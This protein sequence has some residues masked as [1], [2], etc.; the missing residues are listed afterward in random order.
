[1]PTAL[2]RPADSADGIRDS[3]QQD[4]TSG[5]AADTQP[6]RIPP[7]APRA[8]LPSLTGMRWAAALLV[9]LSHIKNFGY[10]GGTAGKLVDW[11]FGRGSIGVSFF[12]ILS[13]FVLAWSVR[14]GERAVTFWRNR[15]ARVY[16]LHLVTAGIA[17][18]LAFTLIPAL[19]PSGVPEAL[20]NVF[21]VSSWNFEWWQ[22]LNPV[23]WTLTC[24]A[25]FYALFPVLYAALRRLGTRAHNPGSAG[26]GAQVKLLK[27][28]DVQ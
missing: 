27:R 18:I 12:F 3:A 20:A 1:M 6:R 22:A 16:P 15:I 5:D 7:S 25:F 8:L 2:S 10:F 21:L 13:G 14:D 19:R 26:S 17:V 23:S 11:A 4:T 28:M 9:F 24:E